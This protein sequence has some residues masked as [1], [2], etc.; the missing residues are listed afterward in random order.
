LRGVQAI[1]QFVGDG[2]QCH[3][4]DYSIRARRRRCMR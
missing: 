3:A 2:H 1:L 4:L